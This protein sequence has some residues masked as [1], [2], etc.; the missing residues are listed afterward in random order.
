MSPPPCLGTGAAASTV[1][2]CASEDFTCATVQLGWRWTSSAAAPATCGDAML[3]PESSDHWPFGT[4]ERID[5][6]GAAMSGF[7]FIV[8]GVGPDDEK[9]AI[10]FADVEAPAVIAAGALP[11]EPT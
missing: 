3:V 4:D 7:S 1:A 9:Y 2:V 8:I 10:A 6:P 5:A 11:G